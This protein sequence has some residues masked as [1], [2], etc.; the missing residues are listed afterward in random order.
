MKKDEFKI[1]VA[2]DDEMIRD[3]I[4]KFLQEEGYSVVVADDG[5]AAIK[6]VRIDDIKLVLTDLRMPGADGMEVLRTT[7]GINSGIFVVLLT[8]YG[9]LDTALDAMKEGAYDYI[10]KPFVMQQLLLVVRNAYK[11]ANLIEEN[12]KLSVE[13]KE[14]YRSLRSNNPRNEL[15]I[16][17]VPM[18]AMELIDTLEEMGIINSEES[19]TLKDRKINVDVS[20]KE[21][22]QK[23]TDLI[24]G[25]EGI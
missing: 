22:I 9:T 13:L 21:K 14:V 3:V 18:N 1:L 6:L 23:Y 10:V 24:K 20:G 11:M 4:L 7:I 16:P 2:E 12:Q 5:F 8:A 17:E 25:L 15:K 19:G